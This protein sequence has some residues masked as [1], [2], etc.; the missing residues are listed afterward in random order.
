MHQPLIPLSS[1][2]VS[3]QEKGIHFSRHHSYSYVA[4]N[5]MGLAAIIAFTCSV[6]LAKHYAYAHTVLTTL[7]HKPQ[8]PERLLQAAL[9]PALQPA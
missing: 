3:V 2:Q 8:L 5:N 1:L 7:E 4:Y 9:H 6:F